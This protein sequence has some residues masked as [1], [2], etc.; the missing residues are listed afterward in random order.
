MPLATTLVRVGA[1]E[2]DAV[3][4][5][6]CLLRRCWSAVP[7]VSALVNGSDRV[8]EVGAEIGEMVYWKSALA[9]VWCKLE[10]H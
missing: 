5:S 4:W 2:S 9:M 1:S 7:W 6:P 3:G 10:F 8:V